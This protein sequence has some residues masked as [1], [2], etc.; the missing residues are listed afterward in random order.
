MLYSKRKEKIYIYFFKNKYIFSSGEHTSFVLPRRK[1]AQSHSQCILVPLGVQGITSA[2]Q[3]GNRAQK[4]TLSQKDQALQRGETLNI[5]L[6]AKGRRQGGAL[7]GD[8]RDS[9]AHI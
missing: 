4:S 8:F 5:Y 9:S 7:Q 2:S 1:Q 6:Q 3:G